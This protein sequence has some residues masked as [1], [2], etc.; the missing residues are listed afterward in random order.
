MN[1]FELF[2][3]PVAPVVDKEVLSAKY[4]SLQKSNHPDFFT[5]AS[6][7][8]QADALQQSADINKAF[9]IFQNDDKTIEYFLLLQDV[10]TP[11]EKYQL[12]QDFLM[13]MM[14]I[15]ETLPEKDG[16]ELAA[17][18]AAIEKPLLDEI[19]PILEKNSRSYDA[20]ELEKL[21]AYY[22]KK[23]YLKRILERLGD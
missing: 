18:M 9:T 6:E 12:P 20:A 14:E 19:Q 13:E 11:D 4:F 21:K 15:N 16:V 3:L 2:A 22:Y 17:E 8:D 1:Y 23:K 10:I 7:S 5:Q